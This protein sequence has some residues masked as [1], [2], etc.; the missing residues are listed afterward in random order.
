MALLASEATSLSHLDW[1][2]THFGFP[3]GRIGGGI[4]D[5][6]LCA[7]LQRAR[8]QN[9][10]LVYW[11][12]AANRGASPYLLAD[13]AG[14]LVD[15]KV[16]FGRTLSPQEKRGE[17]ETIAVHTWQRRSASSDLVALAI[18]A[19]AF[20]RFAV[21]SRI[22]R[23]DF[24]ELY[25]IWIERSVRCE[26]ADAVLVAADSANAASA[27]RGNVERPLAGMITLQATADIAS[28]GLVAVAETHRGRGIGSLLMSAAHQWMLDAGAARSTVVTQAAN[29]PA[30]RLYERSGYKLVHAENFYH[31][32]P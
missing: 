21:D 26:I 20:S 32:W 4:S 17:S 13:F 11:A 23:R 16:T 27:Q 6:E 8:A 14:R 19:G 5:D 29:A 3:V 10:R 30:C 9:Y 22:P 24:E 18:A 25:R 1:D 15:R 2:S 28:I 7:A 12:T 31:F